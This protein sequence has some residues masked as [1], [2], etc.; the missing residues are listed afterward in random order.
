MRMGLCLYGVSDDS[1]R[2]GS[3]VDE[4]F[5]RASDDTY[6]MASYRL[7]T[8]GETNELHEGDAEIRQV[9]PQEKTVVTYVGVK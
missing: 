1:W 6:W 2:H 8:D 5:H 9:V 4:V 3:Y 7:S